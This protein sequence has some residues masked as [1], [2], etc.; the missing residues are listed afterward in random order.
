[1]QGAVKAMLRSDGFMR[2]MSDAAS[3]AARYPTRSAKK[4]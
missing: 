4:S 3:C 1:M 2:P